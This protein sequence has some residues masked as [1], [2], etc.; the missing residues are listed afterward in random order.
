[1]SPTPSMN[2]GMPWER[3]YNPATC[4]GD[5]DTYPWDIDDGIQH[6]TNHDNG[7]NFYST[8]I[9]E[10]TWPQI[11]GD[12]CWEDIKWEIDANRPFVW[13][14]GDLGF[15]EAPGHSVAAWGYTDNKYVIIY[16]TWGGGREDWY[17]SHYLNDSNND[18]ASSQVNAL[19]PPNAWE[20]DESDIFLDDPTGGE[21]LFSGTYFPIVWYQWGTRVQTVKIFSSFDSGRSWTFL[22]SWNTPYNPNPGSRWGSFS[23]NVPNTPSDTVRIRLEAFDGADLYIA[24]D[25]SFGDFRIIR[26]TTPPTGSISINGG[27]ST[28]NNPSVTLALSCIDN[29]D[30]Q[31]KPSPDGIGCE[32]MRFSNDNSAWTVWEAIAPNKTWT[33][34]GADGAKTVYV[35]FRD[36]IGNLSSSKSDSITLDRTGPQTTI[37]VNNGAAYATTRSVTINISC[38]SGDCV[39]MRFSEYHNPVWTPW[40]PYASSKSW[41][42]SGSS[43]GQKLVYAHFQDALGNI[44]STSDMIILD[45]DPPRGTISINQ[46]AGY[47]NSLSAT[48]EL[49]CVDDESGCSEMR[50]SDDNLNWTP[51]EVISSPRPWT[52]SGGEGTKMVY[53]QYRDMVG[54]LSQILS[55]TVAFEI[56]PPSGSVAINNQE[57]STNT[58]IATLTLSCADTYSGCAQMRISNDNNAWTAWEPFAT[59]KSWTLPGGN[60]TKRVYVQYRDGAGNMATFSDTIDLETLFSLST[61][62][63]ALTS[64]YSSIATDTN[65]K[66]HISSPGGA[67]RYATNA[68]GSWVITLVDKSANYSSIAV[69]SLNAVHISYYDSINKIL[70]Y[71][72]NAGGN[73]ITETVDAGGDVG[74]YS[75]IAVDSN[76]KAHIA[77]YDSINDDLK[78]ATNS[79]GSWITSILDSAGDVGKHSSIGVDSNNQS[80]YQLS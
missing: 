70:K 41:T 71:A 13:S 76:N 10:A 2:Y 68:S 28:A 21:K 66:V 32:D 39:Q 7:Y 49:S 72:T 79:S 27:A 36:K 38:T 19:Y 80:A 14:T 65:G 55:D 56:T 77:Y 20:R 12:W 3:D 22:G 30:A 17:Y 53:V 4:S 29:P 34:T 59:S 50:L 58:T 48:L 35:Q 52:L 51:W 46:G 60:G 74:W 43:D 64:G 78:Y 6:V 44:S 62:D 75:S 16:S 24:G 37:A 26:D 15:F 67:L 61:I 69:D 45:E 1:M 47:I 73:W 11:V 9:C 63:A 5:G 57:P 18:I 42:L 8:N 31:G 54:R 33:L 25:G 40:E 23:W